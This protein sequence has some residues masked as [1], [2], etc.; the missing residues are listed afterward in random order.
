MDQTTTAADQGSTETTAAAP[1]APGSDLAS[2]APAAPAEPSAAAASPG[3]AR[4]EQLIAD[5]RDIAATAE[6]T[7]NLGAQVARLAGLLADVLGEAA[8][9]FDQLTAARG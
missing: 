9:E 5:L 1:A 3:R 7:P 6:R 8:A 4:A 2:T